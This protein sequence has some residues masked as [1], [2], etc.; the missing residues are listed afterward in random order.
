MQNTT[1]TGKDAK[2]EV[3]WTHDIKTNEKIYTITPGG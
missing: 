2:G 1:I 3:L